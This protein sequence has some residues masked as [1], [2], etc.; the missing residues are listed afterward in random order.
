M[1]LPESVKQALVDFLRS[2]KRQYVECFDSPQGQK[3]LA[4]LAKFCR[5]H[6]STFHPDSR[7]HALLEGRREVWDRIAGHLQ[8]TDEQLYALYRKNTDQ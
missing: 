1:K 5:A 4:D 2:R 6:G 7:V 3:V 8:L